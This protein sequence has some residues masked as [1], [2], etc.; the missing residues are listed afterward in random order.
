[1]IAAEKQALTFFV[2]YAGKWHTYAKD[3]E[4][5]DIVYKFAKLGILE[6]NDFNQA[7]LKSPDR[8]DQFLRLA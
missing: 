6:I 8:A 1:M 7:K 4:T 2:K 5:T 3:R